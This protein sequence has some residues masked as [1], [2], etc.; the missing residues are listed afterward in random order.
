MQPFYEVFSACAHDIWR[1]IQQANE[2]F[3]FVCHCRSFPLSPPASQRRQA[4]H[5]D[6]VTEHGDACRTLSNAACVG[7]KVIAICSTHHATNS[8]SNRNLTKS[9]DYCNKIPPPPYSNL[10]ASKKAKNGRR[11][12][13][14]SPTSDADFSCVRGARLTQKAPRKISL[15]GC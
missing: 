11:G 12:C 13:G 8:Y 10:S 6:A 3:V 9:R 15:T 1:L 2:D 7:K 14:W 4:T 5:L